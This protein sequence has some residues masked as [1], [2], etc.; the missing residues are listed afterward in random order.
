MTTILGTPKF[1]DLVPR[2]R[3]GLTSECKR[4]RKEIEPDPGDP[5]S[6]TPTAATSASLRGTS[7]SRSTAPTLEPCPFPKVTPTR[8]A[9]PATPPLA[10]R[11]GR[12]SSELRKS[13]ELP[14]VPSPWPFPRSPPERRSTSLNQPSPR[15][16]CQAA[17]R[18]EIAAAILP[19]GTAP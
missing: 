8:M 9:C 4:C 7:H 14:L 1:P 12:T 11:Y 5:D 18:N 17:C 6:R 13:S 15:I 10:F 3:R 2:C 16:Q 19:D